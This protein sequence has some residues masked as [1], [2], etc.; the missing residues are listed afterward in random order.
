MLED[1]S[2]F[3]GRED[4]ELGNLFTSIGNL[5]CPDVNVQALCFCGSLFNQQKIVSLILTVYFSVI[6]KSF[7][8]I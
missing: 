5:I 8:K 2:T 4:F 6:L 1:N 7:I 3:F